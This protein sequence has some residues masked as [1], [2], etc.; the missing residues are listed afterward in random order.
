M[1]ITK[2]PDERR[3]E[4]LNIAMDLFLKKGYENTAVEDITNTMQVAKG[5]FYNYFKSKQD[6]FE[7]CILLLAKETV[8][9]Y[10]MILSNSEKSVLERL[11]EYIEYNFELSQQGQNKDMFEFIHSPTFD[12]IHSRVIAESTQKLI[13]TFTQLI[14]T[15]MEECNLQTADPE[16]T[17]A[18]LLGAL[19]GVHD[20]LAKRSG[21]SPEKQ[22][23]LIYNL[24]G[25][26]LGVNI[27]L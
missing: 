9:K 8:D 25:Q 19:G 21:E 22:R 5:S 13:Q 10:L 27:H 20:L 26:I 1:R 4:I 17:A 2:R 23:K 24:M 7:A 14:K 3:K 15:G 6:V 18:A 16:F 12:V 11:V